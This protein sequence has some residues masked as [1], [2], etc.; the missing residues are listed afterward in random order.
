MINF[1]G[2]LGYTYS[3]EILNKE[4]MAEEFE[5]GKVHK[6][7]AIFDVKKLN[8]I[9]SQYVKKLSAKDFKK[10]AD[11]PDLPDEAVS[12]VTERLEKLTNVQAFQYLWEET[13]YD[14][15][16]LKWKK[17]DLKKSLET[18]SEVKKII[19]NFGFKSKDELRKI[20]DDFSSKIGDRGLAYWP[21]RVALTGK[22]KSPDPV[23]V[24]FV[25]GKE[26]TLERVLNAISML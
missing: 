1:M 26:K 20:L 19:E 24:A 6:S 23:D 4:E 11:V 22:D 2:F 16:L 25:L 18:L 13:K 5:L 3:K 17:S 7:G 14:K 12:M 10:L 9:N 15:E 21:L 8:W